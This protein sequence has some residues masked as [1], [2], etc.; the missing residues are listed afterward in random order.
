MKDEGGGKFTATAIPL[1]NPGKNQKL[2]FRVIGRNMQGVRRAVL[3]G[4]PR[5]HPPPKGGKKAVKKGKEKK[6]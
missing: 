6:K 3:D 5:D 4:P 1:P 2:L